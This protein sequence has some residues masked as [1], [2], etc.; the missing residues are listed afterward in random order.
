MLG[1][2]RCKKKRPLIHA[3]RA[4]D[5]RS[6]HL[7]SRRT[8]WNFLA[9]CLRLFYTWSTLGAVVKAKQERILTQISQSVHG[10]SQR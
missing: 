9:A 2:L 1:G 4:L 6:N 7:Q 8:R 3:D 10:V 5:R